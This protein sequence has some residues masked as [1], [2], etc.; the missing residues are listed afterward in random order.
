MV[1]IF[2][3]YDHSNAGDEA[4]KLVFERV[5]RGRPIKF[6]KPQ[7]DSLGELDHVVM[8]GGALVNDYFMSHVQKVRN[9][10]VVGCSLPYGP[11]DIKFL[12]GVAGQL[13]T[14]ILRSRA[15]VAACRERGLPA[16]FAPDL[17]FSLPKPAP[18]PLPQAALQEWTVLPPMYFG[19]RE[20]TAIV[21]LSDDYRVP[22]SEATRAKF[23]ELE[24]F[25]NEL[26]AVLDALDEKF[27]LMLLPFSVWYSSRDY[28]F[29]HDIVNRMKRRAAPMIIEKALP[30]DRI[31]ALIA[32]NDG[33][34]IS[35]KYH[36]LV[37][38]LLNGKFVINI[39]NTRKNRD[40]M[41]DADLEGLSFP[42][43]RF[44][45]TAVL[46]AVGKYTQGRLLSK[47]ATLRDEWHTA[48]NERL[49]AFA[50]TLPDS[51][52]AA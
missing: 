4:F 23:E 42:R 11:E 8:G 50:A 13:R 35:M 1:S 37:F 27:N 7:K 12:A 3:Y 34:V 33:P 28:V 52:E 30:P 39:G 24:R 14:L 43:D 48:A 36:G 19:R 20:R 16:E 32:A 38:G 21:C 17:V 47:I 5:F 31:M 26:A 45:K 15:D 51:A 25:K 22:Y 6:F 29:A 46:D 44:R 40:L 10:H 41:A 49:A 2:G 18:A 9:L